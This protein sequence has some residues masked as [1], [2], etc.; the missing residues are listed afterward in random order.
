MSDWLYLS[1]C[2]AASLLADLSDAHRLRL[3]F[4]LAASLGVGLLFARGSSCKIAGALL[5]LARVGALPTLGH[6]MLATDWALLA[7]ILAV[8]LGAWWLRPPERLVGSETNGADGM[9][10][11]R[12]LYPADP[13]EQDDDS[14]PAPCP[15]CHG[16]IPSG[17]AH[18]HYCGWTYQ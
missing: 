17:A 10:G 5:L 14:E 8:A 6:P 15:A 16:V 9:D 11:S 13:P 7:A 3:S 12:A 18:C 2:H 4:T 1:L